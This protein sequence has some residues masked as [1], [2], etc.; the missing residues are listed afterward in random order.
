MKITG[1]H[2]ILDEAVTYIEGRPVNSDEESY[3]DL[4]LQSAESDSLYNHCKR[5][6]E[7]GLK[8]GLHGLPLIGGG[9]WNDGM[10]RVGARG[11]GESVW[12]AFFL[13]DV[14]KQFATLAP[15]RGDR[16]FSERCETEAARLQQN[17]EEHTWDGSWYLRAYFDDGRPL[18]SASNMA[19]QIDSLPQSWSVLSDAGSKER[20]ETAMQSVA[21]RLIRRDDKIIQLFDPPFDHSDSDPGYIQGYPPGV[22]E[23]GGQ[24]THAALWVIMAFAK[25]GKAEVAW[26]LLALINPV[27]H[28]SNT[29]SIQHYQVEPYVIAADVYGVQPHAGRG[30]WTWYTGSAGWAYRTI[31]ESLL[32]LHVQGNVLRIEPCIPKQWAQYK[33]TYRF[34]DTTYQITI[35]QDEHM[36]KT[37]YIIDGGSALEFIQLQNDHVEHHVTVRFGSKGK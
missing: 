1:D 4:P 15:D 2:G 34:W 24:Y 14:L 35:I 37:E 16:T 22:R 21:Q 26:E 33:M 10:N 18:G 12:L 7:H 29:E 20:L 8:F 3:Y 5:A 23:N 27:N 11:K 13:F 32:G 31:V 36:E 25:L 17:I 30:G 28:S 6:I 19:C 9:D